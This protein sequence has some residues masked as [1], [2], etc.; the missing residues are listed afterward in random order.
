MIE[1]TLSRTEAEELFQREAA[2]FYGKDAIPEYRLVEL[3]GQAA[4]A[5]MEQ[6]A[7]LGGC[8]VGGRDYNC[9]GN[10]SLDRPFFRYY[11]KA[12]FLQIVTE[13]NYLLSVKQHRTSEAGQIVDALWKA[14]CDRLAKMDAAP[15][16]P[17]RAIYRNIAFT[18]IAIYCLACIF[19]K[20]SSLPATS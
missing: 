2:L 6:N 8:L 9:C 18:Y 3:F 5:Y 16:Y 13:H 20:R 14:R 15:P 4:G 11:Y 7:R 17:F 1:T 12:G 10:C 19:A